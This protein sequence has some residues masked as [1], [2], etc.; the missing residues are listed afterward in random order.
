MA[1]YAAGALEPRELPSGTVTLLFTDIEGST[2]LLQE[3]GGDAYVR[4]LTEHRLLLRQAFTSHGG[5]E[6]EMQGDSFHFAFPSPRDAVGAAIAG[7]HALAEH[8]WAAEPITVRIGLHTGEPVQADGLYAG[9]DVH[10]AARI[11]SAGHGG[12]IL[13]S[14][15][16]AELVRRELPVGIGLR[17]LGHHR[18]KDLSALQR[19]YQVGEDEFPPLRSVAPLSTLPVAASPLVGRLEEIAE[20]TALLRSEARLVTVVGPGGVGK[21]RLALEAAA[22]IAGDFP[23]GVCWVPLAAL[24]EESLVLQAIA[25][26][27]GG[28]T[29]QPSLA[30]KR[31]LLLLDNFE[32]VLGA[33]P[34]ISQLLAGSPGVKA[35]ATSRAPLQVDGE[36]EFVLESMTNSDAAALFIERARG[37]GC[38]VDAAATVGAICRRL[39]NLPLAIELAAA[40]T[41]LL[42]PDALL[43]RLDR[44]LQLLTSGRRDAPDRQRTLRATIDWSYELLREPQQ[45]VLARLSVFAGDF[46]L[47]AAEEI[48]GADLDSLQA[49]VD[50]NLVKSV[51]ESRFVMLETIREYASER[52]TI[53]GALSLRRLHADWFA[54]LAWARRDAARESNADALRLLTVDEHNFRA[55]LNAAIDDELGDAAHRLLAGLWF[56]YSMRGH[57]G[58]I[59]RAAHRVLSLPHGDDT[60][61]RAEALTVG[62]EALRL[63]GDLAGARVYKHQALPLLHEDGNERWY[64]A[65]LTDLASMSA[66]DGDFDRAERL[67]SEA[68]D[69]RRRLGR[70]GGIA[71]ARTAFV[72]IAMNR[73]NY[74]DAL[75]I[76]ESDLPVWRRLGAHA[77]E[78]EALL[79][80]GV[81]LDRLGRL[82]EAIAH[83]VEAIRVAGVVDDA[84]V[85]VEVLSEL[86]RAAVAA[87]DAVA[88]AVLLGGLERLHAETGIP[89]ADR[90]GLESLASSLEEALGED[91]LAASWQRGAGLERTELLAF[92]M[93]SGLAAQRFAGWR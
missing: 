79:K 34:T 64:A 90:P 69:I 73:G 86:S 29:V 25:T 55:A 54:H 62:G 74:E 44:R 38:R 3:L 40:R 48:C 70:D 93:S 9:L 6:V 22:V 42:A 49:L 16:T 33:A 12:Q 51:G 76:L 31:M 15:R 4:A 60:E 56:V 26:A 19:L 23:D 57:A 37:V 81:C 8:T 47:K 1:S 67:A 65:T 58:E 77:D 89:L 21:T 53:S 88:A 61:L 41:R 63:R 43:S 46:S 83:F 13:M 50:L 80:T 71:H 18:L 11:M 14:G 36:Y 59:E 75:A 27:I 52:L 10:R 66:Q 30:G 5:V 82:D 24:A 91:E 78:A 32:H 7:Q 2:R 20:V 28:G 84:T 87:G 17:D 45:A 72:D 39:D 92:A 85:F 35:L 68:L